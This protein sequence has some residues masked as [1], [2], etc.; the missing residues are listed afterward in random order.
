MK[1]IIYLYYLGFLLSGGFRNFY[2]E[3]LLYEAC[4]NNS[5]PEISKILLFFGEYVLLLNALLILLFPFKR[6]LHLSFFGI[7]FF[8]DFYFQNWVRFESFT[9][10]VHFFPLVAFLY[11]NAKNEMNRVARLDLIFILAVSCCF[12]TTFL[13]K[14]AFGWLHAD[15]PVIYSYVLIFNSEYDSTFH[16]SNL[17]LAIQNTTIYKSLDYIV[18]AFQFS[19][20]FLFY[21]TSYFKWFSLFAVVFH[22]SIMLFLEINVF[23][24]YIL[25]YCLTLC[26]KAIV[27]CSKKE[28]A[29]KWAL[30]LLYLAGF[31][32]THFDQLY[33]LRNVNLAFYVY[34]NTVLTLISVVIYFFVWRNR[35]LRL[36]K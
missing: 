5:V 36:V 14:A 25:V 31:F 28:Q 19:A 20:L 10:L 22:L 11:L 6:F 26:N 2:D 18:L 13:S 33:V 23:Y 15:T 1:P 35:Y 27:P 8:F 4:T 9:I 16:L 21:K 7:L 34:F 30:A 24:P 17:F 29:I 32:A 3:I 12:F